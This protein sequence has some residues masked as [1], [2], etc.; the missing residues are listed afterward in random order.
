M[1]KKLL[2]SSVIS[3]LALSGVALA[4]T[5][6]PVLSPT[7]TTT[8]VVKTSGNPVSEAEQ[9]IKILRREMESKIKA[10]RLEY[11]AKFK[12]IR[13][14]AKIKRDEMKRDLEARRKSEAQKKLD[15][16]KVELD[17]K[18]TELE[19]RLKEIELKKQQTENTDVM[20][21]TEQELKQ[22]WYFGEDKKLGTPSDWT[23]T[24]EGTRE[25]GWHAPNVTIG[26]V[27]Q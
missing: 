17:K 13:D 18:K 24:G 6:P 27:A 4:E 9:Q 26:S 19:S 8:E 5:L 21:I 12:A 23:K 16:K 7:A 22:G 1:L 10:L 11:E 15:M 20:K 14:A 25:A 3:F 2:G